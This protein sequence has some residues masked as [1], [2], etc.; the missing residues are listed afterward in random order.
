M[1][2]RRAASALYARAKIILAAAVAAVTG[3]KGIVF[4]LFE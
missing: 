3:V 4:L 2:I 1:V